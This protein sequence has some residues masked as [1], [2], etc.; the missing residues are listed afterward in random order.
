M[1]N[2]ILGS[3]IPTEPEE[4]EP[5]GGYNRTE[6]FDFR[7]A[8]KAA[9]GN[10]YPRLAYSHGLWR[11]T[12]QD[13]IFH[14]SPLVAHCGW[15]PPIRG[16]R[17][18]RLVAFHETLETMISPNVKTYETGYY[19]TNNLP[20]IVRTKHHFLFAQRTPYAP[21]ARHM[22]GWDGGPSD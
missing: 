13:A 1:F 8:I 22:F 10:I 19:L 15:R 16:H 6:I 20:T 14:V 9:R 4:L 18:R 2:S 17:E 5:G 11:V 7:S 21:C 12:S 3:P